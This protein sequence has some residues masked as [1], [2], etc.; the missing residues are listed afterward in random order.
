MYPWTLIL[1]LGTTKSLDLL[2]LLLLSSIIIHGQ[3]LPEPSCLHAEQSN[4]FQPILHMS[5]APIPYLSLWTFTEFV[6]F[7]LCLSCAGEPSIGSSTPDVFLE[8]WAEGKNHL[9]TSVGNTQL[10]I[11]IPCCKGTV[12]AHVWF[13]PRS[14]SSRLISTAQLPASAET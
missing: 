6:S 2:S 11:D 4:L 14:F 1:L 7:C 5:D 12:L 10:D 13:I 8:G 3:E 9:P